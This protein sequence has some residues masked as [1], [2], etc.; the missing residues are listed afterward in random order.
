M[1]AEPPEPIHDTT[2]PPGGYWTGVVRRHRI[3][4][5]TD[6]EGTGGCA[7]LCWNAGDVSERLNIADTVKVQ[8]QVYLTAGHVIL[9]DM[10]RVLFSI[11]SDTS[12]HHDTFGGV[13]DAAGTLARYGPG[14]YLEHRNDRFVNAHDALVAAVGRV[15]LD[16]RDLV[17][18][19]NLFD[20]LEVEPDGELTWVGPA[21]T[22]GAV[23][24]LRAELDVLVALANTPHPYDPSPTWSTG[25][26]Q[27]EV[28]SGLGGGGPTLPGTVEQQRARDN[29]AAYTAL[30]DA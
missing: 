13:S 5:L 14:T 20:R 1:P 10:G 12:G 7:V 29:T 23:V 6:A 8:N 18:N 17:P 16:R 2:L 24:T 4:R 30:V 15:G 26:L 28:L 11:V 27:V 19:L 25:P 9:S 21:A 3:L 22:A